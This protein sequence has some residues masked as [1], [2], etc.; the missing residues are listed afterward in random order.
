[1]GTA[2]KILSLL[3]VALVLASLATL[4]PATVKAQQ[5][6]ITVPDDYPTIST[7][8]AVASSGD[9]VFVKNG[10]YRES[11]TIDKS[12]S[13]IGEDRQNTIIIWQASIIHSYTPPPAIQVHANDVTISGFTIKDSYGGISI[14][15]QINSYSS[16]ILNCKIIGNNF[17]NS[18]G[19]SAN[20]GLSTFPHI[21]VTS[22]LIISQN[23]FSGSGISISQ[24]TVTISENNIQDSSIGIIISGA[25]NVTVVHNTI[26]NNGD[27]LVLYST[28]PYYISGN[29]IT[30]NSRSGIE[31]NY[32]CNKCTIYSNYIEDN[33]VGIKLEKIDPK[34]VGSANFVINNNI[35]NNLLQV[36]T[37]T[38]T[39]KIIWDYAGS[40]NYWSDYITKYPNASK[41]SGSGIGDTPYM[42]DSNN[43]DAYPLLAPITIS[44]YTLDL[45][46]NTLVGAIFGVA[47]IVVG[48][49]VANITLIWRK[50]HF[51]KAADY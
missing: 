42:V 11:I 48:L 10:I 26:A 5:K 36:Q 38:I 33:A 44:T 22:N 18:G 35:V 47:L 30:H 8:I 7:A 27:G 49:A 37:N 21:A 9:T 46:E 2:S 20:A 43:T 4:Q 6:T 31:F 39:D 41:V 50:R 29:T 1:M 15:S 3:I 16:A 19:I 17:I 24:S 34:F 23:N 28:G 25:E 13:L 45:Q 40:G 51:K 12:L 32:Y 14:S